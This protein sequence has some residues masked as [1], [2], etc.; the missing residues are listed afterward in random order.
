MIATPVEYLKEELAPYTDII[1]EEE[2]EKDPLAAFKKYAQ[3]FEDNYFFWLMMERTRGQLQLIP[4]SLGNRMRVYYLVEYMTEFF[5][6]GK[7]FCL[8]VKETA[9]NLK[10]RYKTE[11]GFSAATLP[12]WKKKLEDI[13]YVFSEK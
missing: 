10:K 13:G 4:F 6:Q 3:Y 1:S 2:I 9:Q 7:L 8:S 12:N 11:R 5:C